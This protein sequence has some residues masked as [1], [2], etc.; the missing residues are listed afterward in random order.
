[1]PTDPAPTRLTVTTR[2]LADDRPLVDLLPVDDGLLWSRRDEG[3]I[4][5]G[6]AVRVAPGTGSQRFARA[7][8]ALAEL[9][10][11]AHVDDDVGVPGGG[12]AAFASF[13]FDPRT[14]GSVLVVP[15]RIVGRRAGVTWQTRVDGPDLTDDVPP[16]AGLPLPEP[17]R[18]RVRFAGSS[19]PDVQWLDAVAR[20][21]KQIEDG[22]V[23]KVVLA[24]D[25]A[26]WSHHRLD[27][28]WLAGRLARRFPDC[29]TFL[30]E[31]LIGAT[32]ELLL[33]RTGRDVL[34]VSLAGSAPRGADP[35]QDAA[36]GAALLASDKD[37]REHAFAARSVA[38]A[39]TPVCATSTVSPEPFLLRLD[40]V[41]HLATE[42]AGTL[43]ADHGV[44]AL[45]DR[46]HPTAAVGGTPRDRAV[47]L[48]RGLEGMDR[49]RYA[50][51]VGWVAADG[52]GEFGIALRCAELSGARARLFA[53]AGVVAGSLPEDE[54]EE[55]RVKLRAMQGALDA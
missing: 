7:E 36:A 29:F 17:V 52:D 51:P 6:T 50:G 24:R 26:V 28:R 46:L 53:G 13:T 1:V 44:L 5:W 32:P 25:H 27:P 23:D 20:A 45:V 14:E 12:L 3:L 21:V 55:T 30:V 40:N 11:R 49:G 15:R 10:G 19:L 18:D 37:Q 54:L 4:G 47:D 2:R 16:P 38:A 41:Q 8:A 48:I 42:V 39:L 35:E 9:A 43:A 31:S 33:R 34:S 22:T